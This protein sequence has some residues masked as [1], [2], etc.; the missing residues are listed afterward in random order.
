MPG[1]PVWRSRPVFITS[2]F[3][4]MHAERDWLRTRIF[5]A[6]EERLRERFHHLDIVDLRWGVDSTTAGQ[7]AERERVVLTVCLGEIGRCRPFLVGMLG[8]RYGWIPP[9][10]LVAGA[11]IEAGLGDSI[12]GHSITALEVL[13]GVLGHA[14]QP[15]R[16]WF[17]LRQPLPY[18]A[19]PP[20]D[21]A[22]Y[23]DAH[24]GDA[25]A[26]EKVEKLARLKAS[27][28]E[29]LGERVRTYSATWDPSARA[30]TGL[31]GWGAQVEQDLWADLEAETAAFLRDAPDSWQ[32]QDRLL[33]DEFVENRTRGFVGRGAI[34][35]DLA[36]L[37][38]SVV[39]DGAPWGACVTGEPGSGKSSLFGYLRRELQGEDTLVLAHAAGIS[40]QSSRVSRML[41][42][43]IGELAAMLGEVDPAGDGARDD[44]IDQAFATLLARAA[45]RRRVSVLIDALNQFE[46]TPRGTHLTWLPK[47]WPANARL[48]ATSVPGPG[49]RAI[50]ERPGAREVGLA[51]IER[52]EAAEIVEKICLRYHRAMNPDVQ[53]AL[54]AKT[55]RSG[56][57]AFG[58][59]LW[60]EMATEELNLLGAEAFEE[61]DARFADVESGGDRIIRLLR[62]VV[63]RMPGDVEDLYDWMLGGAERRFGAAWTQAFTSAVAVSRAGWREADLRV[64]I[65]R[66]SGEAWDDLRFATLRRAFRAHVLQRGA[67]AQWD[68]AH[69]QARKAVEA[70]LARGGAD[71]AAIHRAIA[72]HLWDLPA[73]DPLRQTELMTHLV[74]AGD[75]ARAARHLAGP[76][77]AVAEDASRQTLASTI[78]S[79]PPEERARR[80]AWVCGLLEHADGAG[81]M[82]AAGA[83]VR[84]LVAQLSRISDYELF[85]ANLDDVYVAFMEEHA[86]ALTRL[87]EANPGNRDLRDVLGELHFAFAQVLEHDGQTRRAA[88]V[89]GAA[90]AIL[91]DPPP[92]PG[93][94]FRIS[95]VHG[96]YSG[97]GR[98]FAKHGLTAP[99]ALA[100][101]K[102]ARL[103][104]MLQDTAGREAEPAGDAPGGNAPAGNTPA[105]AGTAGAPGDLR[106][107]GSDADMYKAV[108]MANGAMSDTA[109]GHLAAGRHEQAIGAYRAACS[110]YDVFLASA[111]ESAGRLRT[112]AMARLADT[113]QKIGAIFVETKQWAEASGEY[114][115]A[116]RLLEILVDF[117]PGASKVVY[118]L[119][120]NHEKRADILREQDRR[121]E[122]SEA[123]VASIALR[124]RLVA[125][126]PANP[127]WPRALALGLAKIEALRREMGD[128]DAAARYQAECGAILEHMRAAGVELEPRLE[129]M[130]VRCR[131]N[132]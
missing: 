110:A 108:L 18:G 46:G 104:G 29:A 25:D 82:G 95:R 9:R 98:V 117:D 15:S 60:L 66:L 122:A 64:L 36:A 79:A 14:G 5:P 8:D 34:A 31:E 6:L 23:S 76:L 127:Q 30:V 53:N 51:A 99:A 102:A 43:W 40:V 57:P 113:R 120:F 78:V 52:G 107:T 38:T 106:L 59:P 91:E 63:E 67:Q 130:R 68:F 126:D 44:E 41:R 131:G 21:A 62:L 92:A 7:E 119:L 81:V 101:E 65:P 16:S 1:L 37:A 97:L 123:L 58:N 28:G 69:A 11:A 20:E 48:V 12:E 112:D 96:I 100:N 47:A 54:L 33:L 90:L 10:N 50:L 39:R 70:R 19:M 128:A 116:G 118:A 2:T 93:E 109:E 13:L 71:V 94:L 74:G 45:A 24:S 84:P 26:G 56:A 124:R 114:V 49:A 32:A 27:L 86:A 61:A 4:D 75:Q 3:R 132:G 77:S 88:K 55:R 85:R 35:A 89:Y 111:S 80:I 73:G 42:R 83:Q 17:Y 105:G 72:D 22:R 129:R 125:Q 87:S 115:E 103:L 121:A